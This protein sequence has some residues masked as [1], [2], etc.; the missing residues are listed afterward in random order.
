[1]SKRSSQEFDYVEDVEDETAA[2]IIQEKKLIKKK[3]VPAKKDPVQSTSAPTGPK[4]IKF[5]MVMPFN[6]DPSEKFIDTY[7]FSPSEG[8]GTT[9]NC[10]NFF[11]I[12]KDKVTQDESI[13]NYTF[14]VQNKSI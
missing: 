11:R 10:F 2:D 9:A 4:K 7:Q 1:M 6:N 5:S 12:V 3:K 14:A 13:S 8:I